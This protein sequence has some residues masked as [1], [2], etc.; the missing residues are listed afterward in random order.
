MGVE[1]CEKSESLQTYFRNFPHARSLWEQKVA[2]KV[3]KLSLPTIIARS[4]AK[5]CN[6]FALQ[7]W[8]EESCTAE[9]IPVRGPAKNMTVLEGHTTHTQQ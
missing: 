3:W 2:R 6:L 1:S 9:I 7:M 8:Q 5:V 4:G